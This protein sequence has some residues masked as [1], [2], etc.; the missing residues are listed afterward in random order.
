MYEAITYQ[1]LEAISA[2]Y[3]LY[4]NCDY[5]IR[6]KYKV[7]MLVQV[8]TNFFKGTVVGALLALVCPCFRKN[9]I[10][11]CKIVSF[12]CSLDHFLLK[13]VIAFIFGT[14]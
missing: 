12:S 2:T 3:G 4:C 8:V 9:V 5:Y 7:K 11:A 14:L 13:N 10:V 1:L 6:I